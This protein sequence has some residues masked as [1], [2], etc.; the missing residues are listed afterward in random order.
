MIEAIREKASQFDW[1]NHDAVID[2]YEDNLLFFDNYK[3]LE[4]LDTIIDVINMKS[5]YIGALISGRVVE[6]ICL[7]NQCEVLSD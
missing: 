5:H 4:E 1:Q 7:N 3:T 2:F 6:M